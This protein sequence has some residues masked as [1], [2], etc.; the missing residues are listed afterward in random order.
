VGG[1]IY[2]C[3]LPS[4]QIT[5]IV[6]IGAGETD[7]A[8]LR[9]EVDELAAGYRYFFIPNRF[10][11]LYPQQKI[12]ESILARHVDLREVEV[13]IRGTNKVELRVSVRAP[14][15]LYCIT[16]CFYLDQSGLVY[17]EASSTPDYVLFRDARTEY[18]SSTVIGSYP[19]ELKT[20]IESE[21]FVKQLADT[22]LHL[23]EV[24]IEQNDGM[25]IVTEEGRLIVS[26]LESFEMQFE[27]LKT[28]LTQEIFKNNDGTV[29][30]FSYI[31]LRFGKKIFYR[32]G[33]PAVATSSAIVQ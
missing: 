9:A 5:E 21:K 26:P 6:I 7:I 20:F 12:E 16:A 29:H 33:G 28:A 13:K 8:P 27:F 30:S 10:V 14:E 17:K 32:M 25:S 18:A 4:L 1:I 19:M 22:G 31:D 3:R 11:F 2:V 24:L 15:A 23:K